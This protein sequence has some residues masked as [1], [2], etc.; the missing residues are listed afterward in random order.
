MDIRT[1]VEAD[2][3]RVIEL[4][5]LCNLTR[6]WNDP[7]KD[8]DRKL[9]RDPEG[10]IVGEIDGQVVATIMYGYDGHRGFANYLGVDPARQGQGLGRA[11]MEEV[12]TRLLAL[13]CPKIN[14]QIRSDNLGLLSLY[15]HLGYTDDDVRS[16]G[17][18][19]IP[20]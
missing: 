3:E 8:V 2:R 6:P 13:G 20:D 19:L 10:L 17:K 15:G 1:F 18:R 14:L 11:M 16:M 5:T 9:A 4:W 7:G 12:E